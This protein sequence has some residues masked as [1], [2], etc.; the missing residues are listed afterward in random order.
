MTNV[1]LTLEPL[2]QSMSDLVGD[3]ETFRAA[4]RAAARAKPRASASRGT[5]CTRWSN[6]S[7]WSA[8]RMMVAVMVVAQWMVPILL[9]PAAGA[10]PCERGGGAPRATRR[11][12]IYPS[13]VLGPSMPHASTWPHL[14]PLSGGLSP[15]CRT[16]ADSTLAAGRTARSA[17]RTHRDPDAGTVSLGTLAL[18]QPL[19]L[20]AGE[21]GR[22]T[23]PC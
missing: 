16:V 4:A 9:G 11:W 8:V 5:T 22:S 15:S 13:P 1:P 17:R 20:D 6:P 14:M 18:A 21:L 3:T 7:A 2:K 19:V 12:T 10:C 23:P